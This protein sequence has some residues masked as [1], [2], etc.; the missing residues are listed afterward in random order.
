MEANGKT[1]EGFEERDEVGICLYIVSG[2][3]WLQEKVFK[4]E[5]D[6]KINWKLNYELIDLLERVDTLLNQSTNLS[7]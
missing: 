1:N 4:V 6:K 5:Q 2:L 3:G 7:I